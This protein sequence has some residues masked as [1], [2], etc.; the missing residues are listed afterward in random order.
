MYSFPDIPVFDNPVLL[1]NP[2]TK[3]MPNGNKNVKIPIQIN[4]INPVDTV[5]HTIS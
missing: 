2:H 1:T 4:L 3:C 5:I